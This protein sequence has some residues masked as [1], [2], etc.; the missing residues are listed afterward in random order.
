MFP[1]G[2][3]FWMSVWGQFP[4]EPSS[5]D[6]KTIGEL[7]HIDIVCNSSG[8]Y[9]IVSRGDMADDYESLLLNFELLSSID[10]D[11]TLQKY[12]ISEHRRPAFNTNISDLLYAIRECHPVAFDYTLVRHGGKGLSGWTGCAGR[13]KSF[14]L[15]ICGSVSM[16]S[17][18]RPSGGMALLSLLN[19]QWELH[20]LRLRVDRRIFQLPSTPLRKTGLSFCPYQSLQ[21]MFSG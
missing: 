13:L 5:G 8:K 14:P 1:T 20:K 2:Q 3:G 6:I 19:S 11:I 21:P 18:Q 4:S 7:F 17:G 12:V 16:M 15:F 10:S 9:Q